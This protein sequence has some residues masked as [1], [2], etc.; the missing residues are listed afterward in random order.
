MLL[1]GVLYFFATRH[2]G[3]RLVLQACGLCVL[4]SQLAFRACIV[5]C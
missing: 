1:L 5:T 2:P 4:A 3:T